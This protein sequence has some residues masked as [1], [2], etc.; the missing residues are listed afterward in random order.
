[1]YNDSMRR[2]AVAAYRSSLASSVEVAEDAVGEEEEE[3]EEAPP[4]PPAT[5]LLAPMASLLETD[6]NGGRGYNGLLEEG[7]HI[8][9]EK[10]ICA[11]TSAAW[12]GVVPEMVRMRDGYPRW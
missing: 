1:M 3:D 12:Q 9:F 10:L 11:L 5:G 7:P 2:Q 4:P 6:V 8:S